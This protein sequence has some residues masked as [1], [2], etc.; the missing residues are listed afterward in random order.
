MMQVGQYGFDEFDAQ[1][2]TFPGIAPITSV[3]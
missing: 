3:V 1:D 2:D